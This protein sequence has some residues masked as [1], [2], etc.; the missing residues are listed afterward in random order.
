MPTLDPLLDRTYDAKIPYYSIVNVNLFQAIRNFLGN[1]ISS[2]A[3]VLDVGCNVGALGAA[4]KEDG[5]TVWG[6]DLS[7]LAVKQARKVLDKAFVLD[8]EGMREKVPAELEG[9]RFELIIFADV[10]EHLYNPLNTLRTIRKNLSPDGAIAISIPNIANYTIRG[11]LL[12][13]DFTYTSHGILDDTHIRF[14]TQKTFR[15]LLQEAGLT[16]YSFSVTS[17]GRFF[18]KPLLHALEIRMT[19]IFPS[20]LGYQFITVAVPDQGKD[21]PES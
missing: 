18:Q 1:Q 10:L 19:N 20:L 3:R 2:P 5:H 12:L 11:K 21:Q 8:V 4:L 14:F 16:P 9:E 7:P 17:N 13:G 6:C 15:H